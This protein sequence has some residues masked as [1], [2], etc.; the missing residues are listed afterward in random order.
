MGF[1]MHLELARFFLWHF[2]WFHRL[3]LLFQLLKNYLKDLI[4]IKKKLRALTNHEL[5]Y[6]E[7][8]DSL[9]L[10]LHGFL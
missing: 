9:L 7:Q 10:I 5:H 3:R 6:S 1:G 8:G 2:S 4:E